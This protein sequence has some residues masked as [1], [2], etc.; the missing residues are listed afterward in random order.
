MTQAQKMWKLSADAMIK[1]IVDLGYPEEF[2][3][4]IARML[5]SPKAIDRMTGYLR[6]FRPESADVIADEVISI[7]SE[8]DAWKRKK[9]AQEANMRLNEIM[10]FGVDP[11]GDDYED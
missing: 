6:G 3:R 2:G 11:Y 7:I 1:E 5:G 9:S 8:I 4:D 10:E